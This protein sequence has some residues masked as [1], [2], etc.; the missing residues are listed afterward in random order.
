MARQET[1]AWTWL[2]E[3]PQSQP[4]GRLL[5]TL[6][7]DVLVLALM[8]ASGA[9]SLSTADLVLPQLVQWLLARLPR[10]CCVP[11]DGRRPRRC[12][13]ARRGGKDA[14]FLVGQAGPG[15]GE[16]AV[17]PFSAGCRRGAVSV[18][19]FKIF[20]LRAAQGEQGQCVLPAGRQAG[21]WCREGQAHV[22]QVDHSVQH[23]AGVAHKHSAVE[24]D[25]G[26]PSGKPGH[27]GRG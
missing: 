21:P 9:G 27:E 22:V 14:A 15:A 11:L 5:G 2:F 12:E 6:P 25:G 17:L 3:A 20:V 18:P 23:A 26:W 7:P 16:V 8:A 24:G 10:R 13:H 4:R 1:A 19:L